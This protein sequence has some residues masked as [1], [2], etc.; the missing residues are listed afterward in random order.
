MKKKL[1]G[2][3]ETDPFILFH[4]I[5]L[6]AVIFLANLLFNILIAP[7]EFMHGYI[8]L[9]VLI[10]WYY[11]FLLVGDQLIHYIGGKY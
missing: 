4:Y 6:I 2:F 9:A 11:I 10:G 5:P 8:S 7:R 1:L 3:I